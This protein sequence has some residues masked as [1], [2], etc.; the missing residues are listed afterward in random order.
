M[1]LHPNLLQGIPQFGVRVLLERVQVVLQCAAEQHR[2]LARQQ[3][4]ESA[5]TASRLTDNEPHTKCF[6]PYF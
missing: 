1:E 2:V 5:V 6:S 3:G 4:E